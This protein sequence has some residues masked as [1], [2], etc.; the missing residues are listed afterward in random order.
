MITRI[1]IKGMFGWKN[2]KLNFNKDL[3]LLVGLNGSGKTTI[4]NIISSIAS[5]N[6]EF[7]EK[8]RCNSIVLEYTIS[9][10]I[11]KKIIIHQ[12]NNEYVLKWRNQKYLVSDFLE[13]KNSF[14]KNDEEKEIERVRKEISRELNLLYLPLSRDKNM[15]QH[16]VSE[17]ENKS[18]FTEFSINSS[19]PL[20]NIDETL[21]DINKMVKEYQRRTGLELE[22]LNNKMR[23]ELFES[24]L[25][26][27]KDASLEKRLKL[28]QELDVNE[29]KNAFEDM[30][31]LTPRLEHE[32]NN[33]MLM[34]QKGAEH[35]KNWANNIN[36]TEFD[37]DLH[38][39][40]NN[41]SQ[42]ERII[43]WQKIVGDITDKKEKIQKN[44][45][46]FL[47]TVNS[48]LKES[49]KVITINDRKGIVQFIQTNNKSSKRL[50][51]EYLSSGEKQIVIFFAYLIF[52][53][54]VKQKG[55]YIVDEPELSLHVSWQ[56][57]FAKS[58]IA[59]APELQIIFA[60]HSAEIVGRYRDKCIPRCS[61]I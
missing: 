4:L 9:K 46:V 57:E 50:D 5:G 53:I 45:K 8:Y 38:D 44:M 34:L 58:I 35:F 24:S 41:L 19:K 40:Y 20:G 47:N 2:Y 30:G 37:E 3:N 17:R 15:L 6:F 32:I 25:T 14:L 28:L 31:L 51:L 61:Y 23:S 36:E 42:V 52:D 60:T 29:L 10:D 26:Y 33:F 54:S 56:R 1:I 12:I 49:K 43:S 13:E 55:I 22:K 48:F 7:V 16:S 59:V 18:F 39:F 21:K 27:Q 11:S